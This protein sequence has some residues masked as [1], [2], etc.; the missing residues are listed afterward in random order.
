MRR[1]DQHSGEGQRVG[2]I[3]VREWLSHS[4]SDPLHLPSYFANGPSPSQ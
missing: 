3:T 4:D 2:R 1:E